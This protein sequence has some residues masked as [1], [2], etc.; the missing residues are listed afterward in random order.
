MRSVP[1][2]ALL[3]L[4]VVPCASG[5]APLCVPTDIG[6]ACAGEG[7]ASEGS[8]ESAGYAYG[9]DTVILYSP[10]GLVAVYAGHSCYAS[11]TLTQDGT[12]ISAD[13]FTPVA[14]VQF[15]WAAYEQTD[16]SGTTSSCSMEAHVGSSFGWNTISDPCTAGAP[17]NPGWGE[18]LP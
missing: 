3:L 13:V 9:Y 16:E 15:Q 6:F 5:A 12:S 8:C 2:W 11:P 14:A 18:L 4:A 7:H 1:L 10:A 17:P